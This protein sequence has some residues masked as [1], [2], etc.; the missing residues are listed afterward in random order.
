MNH[1]VFARRYLSPPTVLA[2]YTP[3]NTIWYFANLEMQ[4]PQ[5]SP[6][7]R[8]Q[9]HPRQRQKKAPDLQGSTSN[10]NHISNKLRTRRPQAHSPRSASPGHKP[11]P[12]LLHDL[13]DDRRCD[14]RFCH[15]LGAVLLGFAWG[16]E[17]ADANAV[18]SLALHI[19]RD[20]VSA[21]AF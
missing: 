12:S 14:L 11:N 15:Q 21:V 20:V 18:P 8:A 2:A 9:A 16:C 19:R 3:E 6:A 1:F 5:P 13:L 10:Q 4:R 17:Q 7:P